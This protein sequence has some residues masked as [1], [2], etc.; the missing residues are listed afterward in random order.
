MQLIFR[1]SKL[2][3]IALSVMLSLIG[4]LLPLSKANAG[5]DNLVF[6]MSKGG[7]WKYEGKIDVDYVNKMGWSGN[8]WRAIE[9]VQEMKF[10]S[11]STVQIMAN[12]LA[13]DVGVSLSNS[14][15]KHGV[16]V[17]VSSGIQAAKNSVTQKFGSSVAAKV[18]PYLNIVSWS[19]TAYYLFDSITKGQDLVRLSNA[20]KAGK[21]LIY[22]NSTNGTGNGWY[23]WDGS[24]RYGSY[25]YAILNPNKYQFGKVTIN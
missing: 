22:K 19:Y 3:L 18:I 9:I 11:P 24:S 25:P 17:A 4:V 20:A 15:I 23:L 12:D 16:D 5:A 21:G 14:A 6:N 10:L 7:T 8:D 1:K 2:T 13:N